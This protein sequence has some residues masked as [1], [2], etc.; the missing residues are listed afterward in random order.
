MEYDEL[1][2][3]IFDWESPATGRR[4]SRQS[5]SPSPT[6]QTREGCWN[7]TEPASK[8]DVGTAIETALAV[9]N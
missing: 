9:A 1:L 7:Q 3:Q 8:D 6:G 5:G 2:E 4:E